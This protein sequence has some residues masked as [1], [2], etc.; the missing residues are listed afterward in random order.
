MSGNLLQFII[1]VFVFVGLIFLSFTGPLNTVLDWGRLST[2]FVGYPFFVVF[3]KANY[4]VQTILTLKDLA[5]QNEILTRQVRELSSEVA[6]GEKARQENEILRESLGFSRQSKLELISGEVI[7]LD[8]QSAEPKI[9][10][11]R[12]REHG[13]SSGDAVIVAGSVLVGVITDVSGRTSKMNLITSSGINISAITA[14]GKATGVIKGEHGLGM[15]F[16]LVPQTQ[17]LSVG[18]RVLT[19]AHS[20]LYPGNLLIGRIAEIR[21]NQTELFQK[22]TVVTEANFRNLQVIFIVKK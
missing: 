18:D 12:G 5:H 16:D 17:V 13:V 7:N 2:S 9:V 21:T 1:A 3:S 10:I 4:F 20:G 19:S 11:N 15:I 8:A 6:T 14:S 22:A